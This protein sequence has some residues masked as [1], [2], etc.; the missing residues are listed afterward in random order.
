MSDPIETQLVTTAVYQMVKDG[1]TSLSVAVYD[2]DIP[3]GVT[4]TYPY[5]V[6]FQVEGGGFSGPPLADPEADIRIAFQWDAVGKQRNQAQWARDRVAK[7][8]V[9]RTGT[10]ALVVPLGLLL[11]ANYREC[12]RMMLDGP[13]GPILTPPASP[14]STRLYTVPQRYAVDITRA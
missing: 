3:D 1:L 6:G 2:T 9:A 8:M 12:G 11:P 10:G 7:V 14:G 13:D 4:P 5:V